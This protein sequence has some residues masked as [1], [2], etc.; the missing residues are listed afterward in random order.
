LK[1]LIVGRIGTSNFQG[2]TGHLQ[3]FLVTDII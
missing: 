1:L 2:R 3:P